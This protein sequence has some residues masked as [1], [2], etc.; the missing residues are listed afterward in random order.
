MVLQYVVRNRSSYSSLVNLQQ[1][2][3]CKGGRRWCFPQYIRIRLDAA[4]ARY[5]VLLHNAT[6][7]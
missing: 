7:C 4:V 6:E 2:E 1:S 3:D 5:S